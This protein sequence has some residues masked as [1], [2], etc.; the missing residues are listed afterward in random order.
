[1]TLCS[2]KMLMI[3]PQCQKLDYIFMLPFL[4]SDVLNLGV[5]HIE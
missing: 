5:I 2:D 4:K 3:F 1:M